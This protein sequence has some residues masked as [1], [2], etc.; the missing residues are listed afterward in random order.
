MPNNVIL[1]GFSGTGKSSVGRIVAKR[2]GWA[3][4]DTDELLVARFG[5]PIATVF[6]DQGEA[7]FRI[8]EREAVATACAGE[9][10]VIS[11]GGGATIDPASRERIRAGNL[12][13]RLAA[14]PAALLRRLQSDPGAEERPLLAG[15]DPLA[16]IQAMLAARADAYAIAEVTIDTENHPPEA[17][18]TEVLRRIGETF[19]PG[20]VDAAPAGSPIDGNSA[21]TGIVGA[22]DGNRASTPPTLP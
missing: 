18:A 16:R 22:M 11:L 3:F 13:I 10:Q 14:S 8:A 6:R 2:L 15:R 19:G 21:P 20:L 17:V 4:V 1:I 5:V 12:V 7:A 9:R